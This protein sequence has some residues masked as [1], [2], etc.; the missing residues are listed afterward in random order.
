MDTWKCVTGY[1][2]FAHKT[3]QEQ[4][5]HAIGEKLFSNVTGG[6]AKKY[7]YPNFKRKNSGTLSAAKP[8]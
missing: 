8:G 4:Q 6:K 7:F 5:K 3:V 2:V 1:I